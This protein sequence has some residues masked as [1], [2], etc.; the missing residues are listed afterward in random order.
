MA[1]YTA[2]EQAKYN[3]LMEKYMKFSVE[4]LKTE[5]GLNSQ[6]KNGNKL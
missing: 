4:K 1:G 5:L 2:E 6:L 3:E